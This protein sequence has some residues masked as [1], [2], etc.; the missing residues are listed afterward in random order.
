[1]GLII[2]C[3]GRWPRT[4]AQKSL[5]VRRVL[6]LERVTHPKSAPLLSHFLELPIALYLF[7]YLCSSDLELLWEIAVL[8]EDV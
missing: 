1:M 3:Y 8:I 5:L 4:I 7:I 6:N 2:C